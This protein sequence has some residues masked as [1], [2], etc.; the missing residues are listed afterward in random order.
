MNAPLYP[1]PPSVVA[2]VAS[3]PTLSMPEIKVP[4]HQFFGTEVPTRNR[5]FLERRLAYR[6]QKDAF[7]KVDPGLLEC[8]PSTKTPAR[9]RG[10]WVAGG[11]PAGGPV[12]SGS[13]P[14]SSRS[15]SPAAGPAWPRQ[16]SAIPSGRDPAAW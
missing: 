5:Q 14:R 8:N 15:S 2:Q 16:P 11:G 10:R 12:R 7:R 4:G 13:P 6:L 9:G 1:T 3:R